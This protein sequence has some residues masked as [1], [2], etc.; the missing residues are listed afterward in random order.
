MLNL[1]NTTALK[2]N[3]PQRCRPIPS[4]N[5]CQISWKRIKDKKSEP[6]YKYT[7]IEALPF[8]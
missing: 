5:V 8:K 2:E 1:K 3:L 7:F 6:M 4:E